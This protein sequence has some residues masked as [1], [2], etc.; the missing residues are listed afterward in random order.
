MRVETQLFTTQLEFQEYEVHI[1]DG[2]DMGTTAL[3][4]LDK[5]EIFSE[6]KLTGKNGEKVKGI[7]AI[8][9]TFLSE[10][11]E[12]EIIEKLFNNIENE[13]KY[14]K[15]TI[16]TLSCLKTKSNNLMLVE[17]MLI[18]LKKVKKGISSG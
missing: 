2:I 4:D 8:E 7:E 16:K 1:A 15:S 5:Q 18:R 12:R 9:R 14:L 11:K 3:E 10:K 17:N 6:E 13:E